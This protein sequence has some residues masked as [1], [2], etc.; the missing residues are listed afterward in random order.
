MEKVIKGYLSP[1]GTFEVN[2]ERNE[3]VIM[4]AS[5]YLEKVGDLLKDLDT[6]EKQIKKE[7]FPIKY[8]RIEDLERLLDENRSPQGQIEADKERSLITIK[9]T[10][11]H[12]FK[13]G[14][15][16]EQQ[17]SFIP[18]KKRYRVRFAPLNLVAEKAEEILSDKGTL[19]IQ[20]DTSSFVV[21][22][23]EKNLEKIEELV[24]KID[25]L[26]DELVTKKYFLTYLTPE[27]AQPLL[28][29][30]ITDYGEIRLPKIRG[31]SEG[32]E[33]KEGYIVIPQEE[34]VGREAVSER[35]LE[36]QLSGPAS[37]KVASLEES[38]K[39]G[40]VIYVTDLRR[41][42]PNI[43][44]LITYLNGTETA[45][46]II[47]KTFYVQEGSLERM[48]LAMANILGISP[49]DI[50]GLGPEREWMQM[51]VQTLEIEL[52]TVGPK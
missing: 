9:D 7:S 35:V 52:G 43:D 12:L 1:E 16:I 32:S 37:E 39:E 23:V 24:R 19:E 49:D 33:E 17:D 10:S 13:L 40:N 2:E 3:L 29:G 6:P 44:A 28:Q 48:A 45:A 4:D 15:L 21:S 22:D 34:A 18:K 47:T 11:Y 50:E 38:E 27:E 5:H 51:K 26:E 20:E 46:Q 8:A 42:S 36:R 25:N 31:T 14:R 41:N 30:L